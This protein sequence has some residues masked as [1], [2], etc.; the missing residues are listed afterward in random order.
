MGVFK[1]MFD[2]FCSLIYLLLRAKAQ[3]GQWENLLV[4]MVTVIP[5]IFYLSKSPQ[6][7]Y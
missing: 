7:S 3:I 5:I 6:Q 1:D 4:F 2:A